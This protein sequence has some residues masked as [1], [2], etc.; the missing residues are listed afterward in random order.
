LAASENGADGLD[1]ASGVVLLA[2]AFAVATFKLW[3]GLGIALGLLAAWP[4]ALFLAGSGERTRALRGFLILGLVILL[5]RLFLERYHSD[6]GAADLRIHYTFIG[7]LLGAIIPFTFI[8]TLS[9][10]RSLAEP[11]TRVEAQIAFIGLIAALSPILLYLVW[12]IKVVLGFVFGLTAAIAF[13]LM[14]GLSRDESILARC[15]VALLVIGSQ[16]A[17]ITFTG[18]LTQLELTRGV[19]ILVLAVIV[20]IAAVW[21]VMTAIW[22]ARRAR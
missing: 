19:R 21:L 2:V 4:V 22:S 8:S 9:R 17:A 5:F 15:S 20:L 10:M 11:G 1:A 13:L 3:S 16:L 18:P 12:D 7:A 6:I 14:V